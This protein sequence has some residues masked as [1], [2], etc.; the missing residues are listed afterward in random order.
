MKQT[1]NSHRY[2]ANHFDRARSR[3]AGSVHDG[4]LAGVRYANQAFG[5][6]RKRRSASGSRSAR[7]GRAARRVVFGLCYRLDLDRFPVQGG[8]QRGS[9]LN[10][11]TGGVFQL[12]L[13]LAQH[14]HLLYP[15]RLD[16][17]N[18][19][20]IRSAP[21]PVFHPGCPSNRFRGHHDLA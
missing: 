13:R 20:S 8:G 14:R 21:Q 7:R 3:N 15:V 1:Q 5:D 12:L 18:T 4:E 10:R 16:G 17:K 9:S 2:W 19:E 6:I 11:R